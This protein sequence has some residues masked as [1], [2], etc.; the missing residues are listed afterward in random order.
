MDRQMPTFEKCRN[1]GAPL[2]E[3]A[4]ARSVRCPYC[5]AAEGRRV[6]PL[7]LATAL[8]A[9]AGSTAELFKTLAERLAGELPEL[10]RVERRGGLFSSKKI[11]AVEVIFEKEVFRLRQDSGRLVAERAE[12]VRGIVVKTETAPLDRWLP[13]LCEALSAHASSSAATH[14]ALRRLSG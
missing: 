8:R 4:D 2:E 3:A 7:R 10:V 14:D 9:E 6:D 12:V 1:C 13:A 5:G 11:E